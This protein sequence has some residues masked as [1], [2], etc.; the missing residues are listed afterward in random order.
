M[1][2]ADVKREQAKGALKSVVAEFDS[3]Q[4]KRLIP[5]EDT[6]ARLQQGNKL[7]DIPSMNNDFQAYR[8]AYLLTLLCGDS[9]GQ[10]IN[11]VC[12]DIDVFRVNL[13]LYVQ[14]RLKSLEAYR[15][16]RNRI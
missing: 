10:C 13:A 4:R 16:K 2:D 1:H 7:P 5:L 12:A 14:L 11:D 3:F 9:L 8:R 6:I 15:E